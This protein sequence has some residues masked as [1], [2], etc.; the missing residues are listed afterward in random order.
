MQEYDAEAGTSE[1]NGTVSSEQVES[2]D[3]SNDES[4]FES[5]FLLLY[6]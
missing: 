2:Q 5:M 6:Y 4:Y 3:H 1:A